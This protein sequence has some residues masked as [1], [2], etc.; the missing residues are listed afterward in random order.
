MMKNFFQLDSSK[1]IVLFIFAV[2]A[3]IVTNI[4]YDDIYNKIFLFPL[5]LSIDF[6]G[7]YKNLTIK[8]WIND[9][10][11]AVFFLFVGLELKREIVIGELSTRKKLMTPVLAASIGVLFPALIYL[12]FNSTNEIHASGW[13]IPAATD[14]AFAIGVLN[15]FGNKVHNSLK[16]FLMALAVLDDLAAII[17]IALF[18][19][20]HINI[21]Y[22]DLA[23]LVICILFILN[24]LGIT[25]ISLYAICGM[26]LWI[27][28]LKSGIHATI[29]GILLALF[30]PIST[31]RKEKKSPLHILENKLY[32][33]VGYVILPIF[34]FA[35]SGISFKGL[36]IDILSSNVVIGIVAGL[37]IGKQLG[38]FSMVYLLD[39]LKIFSLFKHASKLE[40]YGVCILTGIGF[41][42]SL[43]IGNLAFDNSHNLNN[44]VIIGVLIASLL[45]G[46]IG[47]LTIFISIKLKKKNG[48][49][50]H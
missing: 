7:I 3:I 1:G 2:L 46:I 47:F 12:H 37:F 24:K 15:L 18:Y 5:P 33:V 20:D 49:L 17:I 34:A 41:T 4:G 35:N 26:F 48:R 42:M 44:E 10:L 50:V 25:R 36:S 30:I 28:I 9:A 40:V 19:S 27:F 22:I 45:S 23:L 43:F 39:K 11:M 32:V 14:I 29:A 8:D 13:A 31:K 21:Y 6:L 38:V 16:V